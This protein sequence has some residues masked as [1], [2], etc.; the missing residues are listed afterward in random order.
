[1]CKELDGE[2]TSGSGQ[3]QE[4]GIGKSPTSLE[5][6][7]AGQISVTLADCG[8]RELGQAGTRWDS[9]WPLL[10]PS[11]RGCNSLQFLGNLQLRSSFCYKST[12][13]IFQMV[14]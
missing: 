9:P 12:A 14:P 2:A 13:F 1:M 10:L 11:S 8:H 7:E 3:R 5:R 4:Q 6:E